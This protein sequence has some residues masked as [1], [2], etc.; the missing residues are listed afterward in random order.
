M[1]ALSDVLQAISENHRHIPYRNSKLTQV[2]QDTIGGDAKLLIILC[3]SPAPK[4]S[5][6]SSQC[7]SFGKRARQ[8]TRK[9][10]LKLQQNK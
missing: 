3:V 10:F 9:K 1:S 4:F 5:T 8:V 7:L 6:E 2:L